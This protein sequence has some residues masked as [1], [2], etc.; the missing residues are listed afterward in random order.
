MKTYNIK[1]H[2]GAGDETVTGTLEDAMRVADEGAAYTQKDI[3]IED[4][5]GN[6]ITRRVWFGTGYD[7]DSDSQQDP[8]CFGGFGFYADWC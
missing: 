8:I 1:Y 4:S 3:T 2:T 6:E 7:P 5:D